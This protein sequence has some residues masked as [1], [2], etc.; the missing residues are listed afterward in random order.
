MVPTGHTKTINTTG[1][2]PDGN[3]DRSFSPGLKK[4]ILRSGKVKYFFSGDTLGLIRHGRQHV[5]KILDCASTSDK[6][7]IRPGEKD[8]Y[9]KRIFYPSPRPGKWLL[10]IAPKRH[11]PGT[12]SPKKINAQE[13][14]SIRK[15]LT[16][17]RS[18]SEARSR[19]GESS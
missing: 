7:K 9:F 10:A 5:K 12:Y 18:Y 19:S 1:L 6:E 11:L 15:T 2:R 17:S 8:V 14:K 4:D 13:R 16:I 3:N